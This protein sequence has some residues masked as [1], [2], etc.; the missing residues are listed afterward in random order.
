MLA[1]PDFIRSALFL[2]LWDNILHRSPTVL[3]RASPGDSANPQT[4]L[5]AYTALYGKRDD[6]LVCLECAGACSVPL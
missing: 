4:T 2:V 3:L 5:G 6:A 1:A